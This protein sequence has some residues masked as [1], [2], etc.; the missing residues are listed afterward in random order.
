MKSFFASFLLLLFSHLASAQTMT[1]YGQ[2]HHTQIEGGCWYLQAADGKHYE[3]TGDTSIINPMRV[4]GQR[5]GIQAEIAKGAASICMVGEIVRVIRR[6][7]SVRYATDPLIM[8]FVV[9]GNVHKA[10]NGYWYV[11]AARGKQYEFKTP[12]EKKYRHSGAHFHQKERV[13]LDKSY[14]HNK[15]MDGVILSDNP[16]Q[17][18]G[19]NIPKKYDPR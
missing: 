6:I 12:P 15:N 8:T 3:L 16:P 10:K 18:N 11:I 2:M 14:T 9:D 19:K 1:I 13:L 5:V 7:D 17:P 4:D